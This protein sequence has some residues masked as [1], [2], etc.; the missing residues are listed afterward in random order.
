MVRRPRSFFRPL[1][2]ASISALSFAGCGEGGAPGEG[3]ADSS[4]PGNS[5]AEAGSDL[6]VP[7]RGDLSSL[8]SVAGYPVEITDDAGRTLRLEAPP[9][10]ILSLVP[11]ATEVL[12]ALG[13]RDRIVGRTDYDLDPALAALPSVGGGL[14]P[15]QERIVG[16]R[17]DLV[18]HFHS[19]ADIGTPRL[20]DRAGIPRLVVR[21]DDIAD[22]RRIIALLG[23]SV[24]RRAEAAELIAGIDRDLDEIAERVQSAPKRRAA[25]LLGGDPPLVAGEGTYLHELIEVAGGENVFADTG[26]LYAPVSLET[27]V[28]R[29]VELVLVLGEA[30]APPALKDL[31]VHVVPA[32]LPG[33]SVGE[34]ARAI[35]RIFHP[36]L[37][38]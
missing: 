15:S 25:F 16:L 28:R 34:H 2:L 36:E 35:A 11:S 5:G 9:E 17:P 14:E 8:L 33:L 37:F 24:D 4:A 10:R 21:P 20:L 32:Q 13:V 30:G 22:I 1:V 29:G 31:P 23:Q 3:R 38:Q 12:T 27:F 7:S 26:E 19:E 6:E 18:V